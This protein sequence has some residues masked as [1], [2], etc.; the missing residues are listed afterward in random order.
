LLSEQLRAF[1]EE[2]RRRR[3]R[4][5]ISQ[6]AVADAIALNLVPAALDLGWIQ[7]K[8]DPDRRG[9][10]RFGLFEFERLEPNR[11]SKLSFDFRYG[12]EAEVWLRIAIWSVKFGAN[13]VMSSTNFGD[14]DQDVKSHWHSYLDRLFR[15]P[16]PPTPS[17]P[18]AHAI[19]RASARLQILESY[20]DNGIEKEGLTLRRHLGATTWPPEYADR[21]NAL[22]HSNP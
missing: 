13:I 2:E 22:R 3:T 17:D 7:A 5:P 14:G 1:D 6:R 18:I 19:A 21:M 16:T 12:Y 4:P 20:L 11:L 9:R 10:S 15:R 8:P